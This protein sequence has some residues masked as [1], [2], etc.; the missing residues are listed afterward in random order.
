MYKQR[1]THKENLITV[2]NYFFY[3]KNVPFQRIH[4]IDLIF[5]FKD[6]IIL[7]IHIVKGKY[8]HNRFK[9]Y[10]NIIC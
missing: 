8:Q 7:C 9:K 5:K 6:R 2:L 3:W 4:F 10:G 1:K